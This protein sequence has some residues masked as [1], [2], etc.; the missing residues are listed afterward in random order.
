MFGG[1]GAFIAGEVG[2][3]VKR[4]VTVVVLYLVA[5]FFVVAAGGYALSALHTVLTLSY[6][7]VAASLWIAGGLFLVGIIALIA[8]IRVKN[9]PRPARPLAS[10]ALVAA[11]L[12]VR[13][14]NTRRGWKLGAL[15]GLLVGGILLGRNLFGGEDE[16]DDRA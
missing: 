6:G 2:G 3:A 16:G 15:A 12:A 5:A 11:P 13:M 4:N 8:A 7:P 10:T 9:R 14:L 1:I